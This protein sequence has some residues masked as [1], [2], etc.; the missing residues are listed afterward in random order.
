MK[1]ITLGEV[2]NGLV[3][4]YK[5]FAVIFTSA[6]IVGWVISLFFR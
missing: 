5:D 4:W 1:D 6:V 3:E 2:W